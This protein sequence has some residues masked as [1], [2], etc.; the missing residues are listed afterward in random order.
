MIAPGDPLALKE[1][2][3]GLVTEMVIGEV[4]EEVTLVVRREEPLLI[5]NLPSGDLVE[6]LGLAAEVEAMV[7][8][9]QDQVVLL[10]RQC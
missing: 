10:E 5:S 2:V 6:G 4:L 1:T 3:Q 8:R 9:L 7:Q